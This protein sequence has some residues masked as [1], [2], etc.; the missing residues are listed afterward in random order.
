ML[1]GV[2]SY[3]VAHDAEAQLPLHAAGQVNIAAVGRASDDVAVGQAALRPSS[4]KLLE[5]FG[6]A[7]SLLLYYVASLQK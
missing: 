5:E 7:L 1:L 2:V 6:L 4:L 3:T